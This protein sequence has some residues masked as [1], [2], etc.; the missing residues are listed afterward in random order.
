MYY[1]IVLSLVDMELSTILE[2]IIILKWLEYN[3]SFYKINKFLF[4]FL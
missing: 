3:F 2:S 4:L 1:E